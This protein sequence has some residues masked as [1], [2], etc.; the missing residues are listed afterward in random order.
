MTRDSRPMAL[1]PAS[2]HADATHARAPRMLNEASGG[3]VSY[4]EIESF[5]PRKVKR[6]DRRERERERERGRAVWKIGQSVVRPSVCGDFDGVFRC[7][8]E[9]R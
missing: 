8:I 3:P 5:P 6:T 4:A 7:I 9:S 1:R 2:A